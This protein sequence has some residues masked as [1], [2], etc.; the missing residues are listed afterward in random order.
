MKKAFLLGALGFLAV[1]AAIAISMLQAGAIDMAA[2]TPHSPVVHRLI[3]WARERSIAR[4][5]ADIISPS[6]LSDADRIHRGA[7]N[8]DAMCVNC[9]LSPGVED[10]EIRKGLNPTPPNLA[11]VA[12]ATDP[13]SADARQYWIIKHGVKSSGMPAWSKTGME[14]Q[15]IWDLVAFVKILPSLSP[16]AYRR[17][18]ETSNGHSHSGLEDH[19]AKPHTHQHGEHMH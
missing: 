2:D 19:S 17:Q 12:N 18:I 15:A 8:Y 14:D 13:V 11:I 3:E 10:S 5:D 4:R 9:H 7:D 1:S 6:D 16:E